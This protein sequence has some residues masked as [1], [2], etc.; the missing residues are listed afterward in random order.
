MR[1][2]TE[3]LRLLFIIYLYESLKKKMTCLKRPTDPPNFPKWLFVA[4]GFDVG[5]ETFCS[6]TSSLREL[7]G[8]ISLGLMTV[9]LPIFSP[10]SAPIRRCIKKMSTLYQNY[11]SNKYI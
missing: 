9:G 10:T 5:R 11:E 4:K 2:K 3:K 8:G 7:S 6:G 1:Y